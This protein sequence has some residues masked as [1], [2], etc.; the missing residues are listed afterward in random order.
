MDRG[1]MGVQLLEPGPKFRACDGAQLVAWVHFVQVYANRDFGDRIA[2]G[3]GHYVIAPSVLTVLRRPGHAPGTPDRPRFWPGP[4]QVLIA[5]LLERCSELVALQIQRLA[6]IVWPALQLAQVEQLTAGDVV[7]HVPRAPLRLVA[8]S[9]N[10]QP[11][12]QLKQPLT[13]QLEAAKQTRYLVLCKRHLVARQQV[14]FG[15]LGNGGLM[16]GDVWHW[17][18]ACARKAR[19]SS[20]TCS[21]RATASRRSVEVAFTPI[22]AGMRAYQ[23]PSSS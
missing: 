10:V 3:Q 4:D 16:R 6:R 5:K 22:R 2:S 20:S 7:Q 13:R 8:A 11:R 9:V 23:S 12:T 18:P 14:G 1:R 19:S 21:A 15:T 17:Q